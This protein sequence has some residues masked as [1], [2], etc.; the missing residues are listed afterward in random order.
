[1]TSFY[2]L[3]TTVLTLI[4][5]LRAF[6]K[7]IPLHSRIS[8]RWPKYYTCQSFTIFP[9]G[10]LSLEQRS[11]TNVVLGHNTVQHVVRPIGSCHGELIELYQMLF[12]EGKPENRNQNT[13]YEL[14]SQPL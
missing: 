7:V 3:A 14:A 5:L 8:I 10:L 4:S 6:Y 9:N 1:M 13:T 12:D 2:I 11:Q